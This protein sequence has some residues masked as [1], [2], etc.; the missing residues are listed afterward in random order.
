MKKLLIT[1]K[2]AGFLIAILA[3]FMFTACSKKMT[4]E[5]SSIVPAAVGSVKIKTDQNQNHTIEVRVRNLAPADQLSP[6]KKTYVV[7]MDCKNSESRNI[8]QLTS[9]SGFLSN[10]LKGSLNTV[11]SSKPTSIFITAE[12]DGDA[13]FPG[14]I[15][16]RAR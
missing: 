5:S 14:K 10:T 7:W 9:S 12:D 13:Q 15:I 4:F 2:L 3:A 1:T 8:G 16:L 6:P 11:S